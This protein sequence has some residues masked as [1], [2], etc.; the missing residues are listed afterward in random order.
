MNK[1]QEIIDETSIATD[2]RKKV[3]ELNNLL[4]KAKENWKMSVDLSINTYNN[5]IEVLSIVKQY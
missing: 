3:T 1:G 4:Q 5:K 2:I